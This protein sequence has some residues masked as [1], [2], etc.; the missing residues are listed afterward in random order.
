MIAIMSMTFDEIWNTGAGELRLRVGEFLFHA[1]DPVR[2]L[3]RVE[4]G[5]IRLVRP[6]PHGAELIVQRAAAP[7]VL[8]EASLFAAHYHC[9]AK[10]VTNS[11]LRSIPVARVTEAVGRTPE[12]ARSFAQ[13]LALEVQRARA[14]AEIVSLKTVG[15]RL[16]AWLALNSDVLLP[17]GRWREVAGEIGVTPEALYRELA[18]RRVSEA[19]ILS[20]NGELT[21]RS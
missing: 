16:D 1:G 18:R 12:L 21:V 9:D 13:Y 8:A 4:S 11:C 20:S 14:R 10:A 6:L 19:G 3:Y 7:I 15:N 2:F 5:V 17:R